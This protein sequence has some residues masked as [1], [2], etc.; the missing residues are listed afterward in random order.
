MVGKEKQELFRERKTKTKRKRKSK[1]KKR[2]W[3]F[4]IGEKSKRRWVSNPRVR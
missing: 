2:S 4:L 3:G 1:M